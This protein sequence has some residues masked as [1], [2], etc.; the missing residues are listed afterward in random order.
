M[1]DASPPDVGGLQT[2]HTLS[3]QGRVIILVAAFLG[4]MFAGLEMAMFLAARPAIQHFLSVEQQADSDDS[5]EVGNQSDRSTVDATENSEKPVSKWFARYICAFLLGAACG[6]LAFG[7]L[8]DH[9]GRA[10]TM[11]LSIL[12]YSLVTGASYYVTD[13]PQFIAL[14]FF[15]CMGIGGMWPAGVALASEAWPDGYRPLLAGLIGT[16]A[17]IGLAAMGAI[18]SQRAITPDDW[19]WVMLVGSVPAILGLIVLI[20]VPESP[21][22]L[23]SRSTKHDEKIPIGTV[24]RPPYLKLTVI[25]ILLGTVPLLGGWGSLNWLIP[26][27][28]KV[29]DRIGEPGLKGE[30]QFMRSSGA[31][32]GS[33]LGG[34]LAS[35]FG[36]RITYFTISF[37]SLLISGYIFWCLTPESPHFFKWVFV[38]GFSATVY[39]GW[40]PLYL[41]ELFPTH[42]RSTG[43][44]VTFN[45]GRIVSAGGVLVAG[46]LVGYF[47]GDYAKAG[48]VTHLIYAVGMLVILFAPDTSGRKMED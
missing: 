34:V 5:A 2:I 20:V 15:A 39:F 10:K 3:T 26:W 33:L 35:F 1:T 43:S 45:F 6:G 12:C 18:G 30:T 29:G 25:G 42:V 14:R 7:W 13:L 28:D 4:W 44:G 8:G 11:G 36:R 31:A 24:F 46:A 23:M 22:W 32:V 17:N 9:I 37:T 21:R 47:G 48:R 38:M 40:F 19:R 27:A 16:S 41:P